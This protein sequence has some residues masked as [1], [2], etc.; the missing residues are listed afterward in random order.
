METMEKETDMPSLSLE[1]SSA[2][3]DRSESRE[4]MMAVRTT[5]SCSSGQG[6]AQ[7]IFNPI[8]SEG[9]GCVP[10]LY[11]GL[12]QNYGRVMATSS[13]RTYASCASKDCCSQCP[14]PTAGRCRPTPPLETPE[15]SQTS[16]GSVS[17][18]ITAPLSCVL[19]CTRL[20]LCPPRVSVSPVPWQFCNQIAL[21]LK[22]RFSGDSQSLCQIPRLGSLLW[23]LE[24]S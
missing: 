2:T 19:L 1:H 7:Q 14:W 23:S 12:R 11:F 8:S 9:W 22:V 17:C 5:G 10:S 3:I 18:E 24:F 13:K 6:Y 4:I 16:L 15:H 20:C 21:T